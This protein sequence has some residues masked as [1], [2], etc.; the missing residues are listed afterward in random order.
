MWSSYSEFQSTGGI[1]G[2]SDRLELFIVA[3]GQVYSMF[4]E[5]MK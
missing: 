5:T 2:L 4:R 1:T 3:Y